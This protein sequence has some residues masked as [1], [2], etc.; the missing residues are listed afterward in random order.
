MFGKRLWLEKKQP[1]SSN[2]N[3]LYS[4]NGRRRG[5]DSERVRFTDMDHPRPPRAVPSY[6]QR[7]FPPT[8]MEGRLRVVASPD[9]ENGA[10]HLDQ[11]ARLSITRLSANSELRYRPPPGRR[12]YV[13]VATGGVALN[14]VDLSEGGA[15]TIEREPAFL[16]RSR[17]ASEVLLFDL[18]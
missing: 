5:A 1:A 4:Y 13:F 17:E 15:A 8:E 18:P 2:V 12:T 3:D 7:A 16:L 6:E 10:V 11:D 9:R 14:D